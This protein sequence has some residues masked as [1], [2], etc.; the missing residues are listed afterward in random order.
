MSPSRSFSSRRGDA[1]R[2][3]LFGAPTQTLLAVPTPTAAQSKA[4]RLFNRLIGQIRQ[5][6]EL[7]GQWQHCETRYH[8][9]LAN[10]L[11][12]LNDQL[13]EARPTL[14]K[15]LDELLCDPR[16]ESARPR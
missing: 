12:P 14:V 6:R 8:R 2:A 10:E 9:R 16:L 3:D 7:L 13:R 1:A 5:Q 15:L 11:Q 4:Q